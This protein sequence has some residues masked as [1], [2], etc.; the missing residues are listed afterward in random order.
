VEA[1]AQELAS[2]PEET[3]AAALQTQESQAEKFEQPVSVAASGLESTEAEDP[4]PSDEDLAAA[5]RLLTP[6]TG[7]AD[8]SMIPS[9]GMLVAAGQLLA[10]EAARFAL[11]APRWIA[12]PV[13]MTPE[14]AATSLE[15]EMFR[16]FGTM[17]ASTSGVDRQG[18]QIT[19]VSAI[20]AT[21]ENRLAEAEMAASAKV[22]AEQGIERTAAEHSLSEHSLSEH[23]SEATVEAT[24]AGEVTAA[25]SSATTPVEGAI[26]AENVEPVM[27]EAAQ[28]D[29][30]AKVAEEV[31]VEAVAAATLAAAAGQSGVGSG[32]EQNGDSVSGTPAA[33]AAAVVSEENRDSRSDARGRQSMGKEAKSKSRKSN[34]RQIR[35]AAPSAPA[36]SEA[37]EAT[38]PSE[39]AAEEAPKTMA[40]AAAAESSAPTPNPASSMPDASTIAS[41]VD[42][43]MADL[44]PK[45]VEEIARKLAKR[46]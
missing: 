14:E 31:P 37:V 25:V 4:A 34:W 5:L 35:T 29:S 3:T 20:A 39:P 24:S 28:K 36:S 45:I 44:R 13:A 19:G 1:V 12:E 41:I 27:T 11:A 43:V 21:V 2:K 15:A 10:E 9:R 7:Q 6:A 33:V 18:E 17:P 23:G 32:A 8:G 30:P 16:T 26:A 42:S 22:L 40:A 38:K 46:D